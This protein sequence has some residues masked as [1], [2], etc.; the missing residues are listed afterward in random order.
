MATNGRETTGISEQVMQKGL[1]NN[2]SN[3]FAACARQINLLAGLAAEALSNNRVRQ[4]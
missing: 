2:Q 4:S 1:L 3:G